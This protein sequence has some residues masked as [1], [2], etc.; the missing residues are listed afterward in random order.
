MTLSRV[1]LRRV[2]FRV[3]A[4]TKQNDIQKNDTNNDNW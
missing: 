2:N 4:L 3:G 1:T